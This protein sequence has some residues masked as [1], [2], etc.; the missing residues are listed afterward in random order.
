[1]DQ[2]LGAVG[3]EQQDGFWKLVSFGSSQRD[4]HALTLVDL[5]VCDGLPLVHGDEPCVFA[6]PPAAE[7]NDKL[8]LVSSKSLKHGIQPCLAELALRKEVG[9]D[10]DLCESIPSASR[11]QGIHWHRPPYLA[12]TSVHPLLRIPVIDA[13]TDLKT[14]WPDLQGLFRS[15]FVPQAEHYDVGTGEVIVSVELREMGGRVF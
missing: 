3:L 1:M 9:C 15:I 11:L 7:V 5:H 6:P 12:R 2:E 13:T 10:D 4:G 8:F 14:A